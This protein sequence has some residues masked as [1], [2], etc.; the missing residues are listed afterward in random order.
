MCHLD[1]KGSKQLNGGTRPT[2]LRTKIPASPR[3]L[4][5][6]FEHPFIC[7]Y[8]PSQPGTLESEA[9]LRTLNPKAVF[10]EGKFFHL[11]CNQSPTEKQPQNKG[12][13]I[14]YIGR[15]N[16]SFHQSFEICGLLP[17]SLQVNSSKRHQ[18]S[19]LSKK[20]P[21]RVGG[22]PSQNIM[23]HGPKETQAARRCCSA[24]L[25]CGDLPRSGQNEKQSQRCY[26]D[27]G[28]HC[29]VFSIRSENAALESQAR[30][31]SGSPAAGQT[32]RAFCSV[33]A[34]HQSS[35]ERS[36]V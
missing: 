7:N 27:G 24:A 6:L 2:R 25:Q 19:N 34:A 31:R 22:C 26:R 8:F 21:F 33:V 12:G 13:G 18:I 35:R 36:D 28:A 32:V 1:R 16:F 14:P 20:D 4:P 9:G 11:P 30:F 10:A 5:N 15:K 29:A 23:T 3:K 17:F